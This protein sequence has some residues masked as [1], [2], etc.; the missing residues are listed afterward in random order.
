MGVVK[1][2]RVMAGAVMLVACVGMANASGGGGGGGGGSPGSLPLEPLVVNLKG[3]HYIQLKPVI[4]LADPVDTDMV[5]GWTPLLRHELIKYMIGRESK[6][7]SSTQF[8]KLFS[9]EVTELLNKALRGEYIKDVI[10]D[11]WVVQ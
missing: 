4:K 6:E 5:K 2:F 3:E 10:F 1:I 9:E 7:A 11:S 8:M